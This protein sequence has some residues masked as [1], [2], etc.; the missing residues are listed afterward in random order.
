MPFRTFS[1]N[2]D[3]FKEKLPTFFVAVSLLYSIQYTGSDFFL[4][5]RSSHHLFKIFLFFKPNIR[6][7]GKPAN[8]TRYS[9]GY[10][11]KKKAGN[12]NNPS[13]IRIISVSGPGSVSFRPPDS[14][15]QK[16]T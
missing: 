12:P 15:K 14:R 6:F 9:V 8:E 1:V 10:L 13:L 5:I 7:S 16:L 4:F 3:I 11:K 2:I